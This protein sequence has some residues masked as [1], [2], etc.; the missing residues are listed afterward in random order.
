MVSSRPK[1]CRGRGQFLN[2]FGCS[3]AFRTQ[4]VYFFQLMRVCIGLTNRTL[5]RPSSVQFC[6]IFKNIS[7]EPI[8]L[9]IGMVTEGNF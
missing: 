6:Q 9:N 1:Y 3:N 5:F 4:Q 2:F 7:R 8:P